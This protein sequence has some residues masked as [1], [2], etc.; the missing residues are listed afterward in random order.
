[1]SAQR[2]LV[3]DDDPFMRTVLSRYLSPEGFEVVGA[4]SGEEALEKL[5]AESFD[6]VILDIHLPSLDGF[7]VCRQI[8]DAEQTRQLPVIMLTAAYVDDTHQD[9]GYEA[10]ADAYMAKP[11][12]RRALVAQVKVVLGLP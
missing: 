2:I 4:G 8:K 5:N 6:L 1:L 9:R 11:F 3:V 12:L 7:Q 10:G